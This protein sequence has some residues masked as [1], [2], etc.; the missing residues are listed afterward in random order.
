M[1]NT[2]SNKHISLFSGY[3]DNQRSDFSELMFGQCSVIY[4]FSIVLRLL[5][6]R[7]KAKAEYQNPHNR[8][9]SMYTS[10]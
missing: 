3:S 4:F 5:F 7:L 1:Q 6:K 10:M 2:V 8:F 9:T